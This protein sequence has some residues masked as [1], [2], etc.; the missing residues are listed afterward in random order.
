MAV[1]SLSC[2][3]PGGGGQNKQTPKPDYRGLLQIVSRYDIIVILEVVDVSGVSI[4]LLL[5]ELNR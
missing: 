2:Q 1:L 4:K 3:T 5:E